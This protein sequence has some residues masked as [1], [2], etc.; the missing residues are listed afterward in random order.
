MG[1]LRQNNETFISIA[2]LQ[3]LNNIIENS[4]GDLEY[5]GHV[6]PDD[7]NYPSEKFE[8]LSGKEVSVEYHKFY[9]KSSDSFAIVRCRLKTEEEE[10][11]DVKPTS[12]NEKEINKNKNKNNKDYNKQYY[13]KH[14]EEM[15]SKGGEKVT[16]QYCSKMVR[17]DGLRR[18]VLTKKCIKVQELLKSIE[19]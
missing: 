7:M 5:Q 6:N 11:K 8:E 16:C 15:L 19:N 1:D 13:N 18:H 12:S 9:I 3:F 14:R 17:R 4:G 10:N 2:R